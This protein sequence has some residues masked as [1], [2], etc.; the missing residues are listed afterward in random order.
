MRGIGL[1]S[2]I[3]YYL[4]APNIMRAFIGD[5]ETVL[6]WHPLPPG[7]MLRDAAHVPVLQ[8]GAFQSGDRKG[9]GL[10][11]AGSHTAAGF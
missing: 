8:H 2:V 5:T 11:L 1:V 9:K 4:L 10:L 3:L 7:K 6:F